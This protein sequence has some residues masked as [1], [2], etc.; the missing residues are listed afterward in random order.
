[1][2]SS[3]KD[4]TDREE[5]EVKNDSSNFT[6]ISGS[7]KESFSGTSTAITT[8]AKARP[9]PSGTSAIRFRVISLRST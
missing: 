5:Q 9:I 2:D 1:M 4:W 3:V 7:R 6:D 8:M